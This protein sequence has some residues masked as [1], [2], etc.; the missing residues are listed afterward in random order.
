MAL[1]KLTMGQLQTVKESPIYYNLNI[2]TVKDGY[3]V[4]CTGSEAKQIKKLVDN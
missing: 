2:Y 1:L 3:E 4:E